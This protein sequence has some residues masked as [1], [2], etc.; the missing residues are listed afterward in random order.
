M[1][2]RAPA[3]ARERTLVEQPGGAGDGG[4]RPQRRARRALALLA[5]MACALASL[6]TSKPG[7][8]VS[9]EME[10]AV[11]LSE[12][13]PKLSF[14]YRAF[15]PAMYDLSV[16]VTGRWR[17]EGPPTPVIVRMVPDDPKLPKMERRIFADR[18]AAA[19]AVPQGTLTDL[20]PG[21]CFRCEARYRV[22]LELDGEPREVEID[23]STKIRSDVGNGEEDQVV[24]GIEIP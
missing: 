19:G 7:K 4:Q 2:S 12:Q 13:T 17:G 15:A 18:D 11:V 14:R 1:L 10:H 22:E 20:F 9:A 21:V 3:D 24:V 8:E 16:G 23:W 5:T 6:A